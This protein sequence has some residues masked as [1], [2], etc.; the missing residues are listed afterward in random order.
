M[1]PIKDNGIGMGP[2]YSDRIFVIFRR[3]HTRERYPGTG[4]GPV[5]CKKIID[6]HGG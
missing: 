4:F 1:A 2:K 6:R 5:T 3:L